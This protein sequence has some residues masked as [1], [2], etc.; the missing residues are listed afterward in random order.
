MVLRLKAGGG[1][2]KGMAA[3]AEEAGPSAIAKALAKEIPGVAAFALSEMPNA[4]AAQ[5]L[6]FFRKER[7]ER[8]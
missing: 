7:G 5:V 1:D 8:S 4:L 3:L 6:V 2:D